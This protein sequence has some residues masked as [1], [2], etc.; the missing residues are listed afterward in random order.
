MATA[1]TMSSSSPR[2]YVIECRPMFATPGIGGYLRAI[3]ATTQ[4]G[5]AHLLRS[6]GHVALSFIQG[7]SEIALRAEE[8][9]ERAFAKFADIPYRDRH[10]QRELECLLNDIQG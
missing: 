6:A 5:C 10:E 8:R 4:E 9:A 2:L 3:S 1:A 7:T